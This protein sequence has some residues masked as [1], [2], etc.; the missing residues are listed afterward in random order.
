[1]SNQ[2]D[3]FARG[4]LSPAESR[5]LAQ[6][7]LSDADLFHEITDI[8]IARTARPGRRR[9]VLTWSRI[10]MVAAA[11][12]MILGV[13]LYTSRPKPPDPAT[14]A[15]TFLARN[16]GAD[17]SS[18][19]G[20]NP[21]TRAPKAV[22]LVQS[23]ENNIATVDLGSLDGLAKNDQVDLVRD[24]ASIGK[25]K[26]TTIFRDHSRGELAARAVIRPADQ[27]RVP[28]GVHLHA[29]LDQIDAATAR[30]DSESAHQLAEQAP[31]LDP[32]DGISAEQDLNNAGV[33]AELHRDTGRAIEFYRRALQA[34]PGS[35]D[36]E[37][38]Q[39]NLARAQAKPQ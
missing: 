33:I 31:I 35:Q 7:A 28:P 25:L 16:T 26:L 14:F 34:S 8:A 6:K 24:G 22:G 3:R 1:M 4:D 29:I 32:A 15:P 17:S 39:K 19:R 27:V 21:S 23:I 30:G 36:R 12:G 37:A 20:A 11:A 38:I 5:E 10:A 13:A 18:F 9:T 2:L